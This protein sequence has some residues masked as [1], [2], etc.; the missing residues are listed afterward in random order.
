MSQS[1]PTATQ[2]MLNEVFGTLLIGTWISTAA[3]AFELTQIYR[4]FTL[5]PLSW[6]R[7]SI[8]APA[9][10]NGR[11]QDRAWIPVMIMWMLA[12]DATSTAAP[13]L[14]AYNVR[15][16]SGCVGLCVADGHEVAC[17]RL[18]KH[19]YPR[20]YWLVRQFLLS[21]SSVLT[22]CLSR[23]LLGVY[24]VC[25]LVLPTRLPLIMFRLRLQA[26]CAF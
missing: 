4:Y 2:R 12:M 18:G 24:G 25:S 26:P 1:T 15:V 17:I 21:I 22:S 3:F 5:Y 20:H 11:R 6:R 13:H 16:M 19:C 10:A 9:S 14:I 23:S 8:R 7:T